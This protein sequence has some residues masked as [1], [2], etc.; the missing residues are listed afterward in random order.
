MVDEEEDAPPLEAVDM[1]E[2]SKNKE[3]QQKE[4]L[5]KQMADSKKDELERAARTQQAKA[6][7]ETGQGLLSENQREW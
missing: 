5:N 3:L 4:W 2:L 7:L 1:E 6:M